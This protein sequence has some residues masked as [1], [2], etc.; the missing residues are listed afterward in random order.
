MVLLTKYCDVS[1]FVVVWMDE[2][3]GRE[4][5]CLEEKEIN[6]NEKVIDIKI[7]VKD[8]LLGIIR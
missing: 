4:T 8:I 7:I 2:N 5:H 1:I 3:D 6:D